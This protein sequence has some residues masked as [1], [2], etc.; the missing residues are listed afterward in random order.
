MRNDAMNGNTST[1][2]SDIGAYTSMS[3]GLDGN[4]IA[5]EMEM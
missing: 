1:T 2:T 5:S 3:Q 4:D